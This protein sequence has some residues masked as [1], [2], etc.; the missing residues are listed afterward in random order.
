MDHEKRT[1]GLEPKHDCQLLDISVT[2]FGDF[3][4]NNTMFIHHLL[5]EE[6]RN[7]R[8][9]PD[10]TQISQFTTHYFSQFILPSHG[11]LK[12]QQS[13]PQLWAPRFLKTKVLSQCRRKF[14]NKRDLGAL[15]ISP[16][17]RMKL[18]F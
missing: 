1:F 2:M 15:G 16:M 9:C 3:A 10:K 11:T 14:H 17:D 12:D 6:Q 4:N 5:Q 18:C 7:M 8:L 13:F